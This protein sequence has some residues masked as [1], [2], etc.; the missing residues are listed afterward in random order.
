[1]GGG[2][3]S[4]IIERELAKPI[5][6]S[7]IPD[8]D[9]ETAKSEVAR[10]RE[11]LAL[12]NDSVSAPDSRS[13]PG[14]LLRTPREGAMGFRSLPSFGT[15]NLY[16]T[17]G[18]EPSTPLIVETDPSSSN[19]S[20]EGRL[21]WESIRRPPT[22]GFSDR[23]VP[24][25][26]PLARPLLE[27]VRAKTFQRFDNL[28]EAFLKLDY[29]RSGYI[30]REEFRVTMAEMGVP[31]TDEEFAIIDGSYSHQEADGEYDR[32]IGYLEF[33]NIM[34]DEMRYIPGEGEGERAGNFYGRNTLNLAYS[35]P[36][37]PRTAAGGRQHGSPSF[38]SKVLRENLQ[39]LQVS[40]GK[41]V[42]EKFNSMKT[43]FKAADRDGSGF[44]DAREFKRFLLE[45]DIQTGEGEVEELL[46]MF[47]TNG[48]GKLA[49][50][51]FVK[52][53]HTY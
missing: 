5:D 30:S 38:S 23:G 19:E 25:A 29:D 52:C 51:E 31:L 43:A 11:M 53:L 49:Y 8:G 32:G 1:M 26:N 27:K 44:V 21:L 34:T 4:R 7:D 35:S 13:S 17:S 15:E 22:S 16:G 39:L 48:D 24:T 9:W 28:R 33:V 12:F 2:A 18:K 3:S 6:A 37:P 50:S 40:F 45:M 47:D 46:G 42:F 20:A 10:M 36:S 41:R 14:Q